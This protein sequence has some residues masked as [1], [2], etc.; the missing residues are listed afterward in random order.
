MPWAYLILDEILQC[1]SFI[2]H[3]PESIS[4]IDEWFAQET[5]KLDQTYSKYL[6]CSALQTA[7]K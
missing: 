4:I 7:I 3:L 1:S 2:K 5:V 6:A